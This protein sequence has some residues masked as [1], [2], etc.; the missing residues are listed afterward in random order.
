MDPDNYCDLMIRLFSRASRIER[1]PV[2]TGDGVLLYTPEVHLIDIAGRFPDEGLSAYAGHPG[3][4]KGAV[5]RSLKNW[6]RKGISN[7]SAAGGTTGRP[8]SG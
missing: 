4:T 6:K 1:E 8:V 5:S 2:D 3:I 7:G